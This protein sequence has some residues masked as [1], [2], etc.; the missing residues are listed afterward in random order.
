M[1]VDL[2]K[3]W[4]AVSIIAGDVFELS[5]EGCDAA[6]RVLDQ[7]AKCPR[8]TARVAYNRI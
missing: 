2:G 4:K 5:E 7:S 3:V 8:A 1:L 6:V